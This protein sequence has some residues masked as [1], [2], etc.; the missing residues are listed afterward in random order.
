MFIIDAY[1]ETNS[2]MTSTGGNYLIFTSSNDIQLFND[3]VR[4]TIDVTYYRCITSS[5]KPWCAVVK[6]P[7]IF[8]FRVGNGTHVQMLNFSLQIPVGVGSEQQ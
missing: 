8:F 4:K 3:N 1:S 7:N 2:D 6:R 5:V